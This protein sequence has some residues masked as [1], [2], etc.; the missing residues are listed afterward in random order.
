MTRPDRALWGVGLLALFLVAF[1]LAVFP[2][3]GSN[4]D[5]WHIKTGWYQV[6][7]NDLLPEYEV[8]TYTGENTP[9]ANHEW[10]SDLLIYLGFRSLGLRGLTILKA[11]LVGLTFALL[12]WLILRRTGSVAFGL[13]FALLAAIS[14]RYSLH[15]RPPLLSYLALTIL[16]HLILNLENSVRAGR[17][18]YRALAILFFLSVLWVNLHGGAIAGIL[19]AGLVGLGFAAEWWWARRVSDDPAEASLSG[20]LSAWFAVATALI[21]AGTLCNPYGLDVHLLTFK[22]MRDLSLTELVFELQTPN[23]HHAKGY[24]AM[25]LLLVILAAVAGARLRFPT[26]FVL[27]FFLQQSLNHVRHLPLFSIVAAPALAEMARGIL[28]GPLPERWHSA[29]RWSSLTAFGLLCAVL[30][31]REYA[32]NWVH[33]RSVPEGYERGAYPSDAVDFL[34]DH[35]FRGRMFNEINYSGYLIYR[36]SPERFKVFTDARF[37]IYG[38]QFMKQSHAIMDADV[39]P[40]WDPAPSGDW[41]VAV[42]E[43]REDA[44][45]RLLRGEKPQHFWRWLLDRWNVNFLILYKDSR[46]FAALH[47]GDVHWKEVY[48]DGEYGIF[49]RDTPENTDLIAACL[50]A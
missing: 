38:S 7:M 25:I 50:A 20:R 36:L 18:P 43:F 21:L 41:A 34:L 8:F 6:A 30:G 15:L 27:L 40:E 23:F 26:L 13:L 31:P 11:A 22:V 2:T 45:L 12:A 32:R 28:A 14:S 37:D 44:R 46:L 42:A 24:E 17:P 10:L 33:L 16:L 47:N 19:V 9:W 4:D 3:R 35:D 5:W 49:V 39:M 1:L 29:V 48:F